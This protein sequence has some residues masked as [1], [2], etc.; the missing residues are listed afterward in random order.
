MIDTSTQAGRDKRTDEIA[1]DYRKSGNLKGIINFVG[2]SAEDF[3]ERY[4]PSMSGSHPDDI[5]R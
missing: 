4:D 2:G 5:R 1:S 3:D